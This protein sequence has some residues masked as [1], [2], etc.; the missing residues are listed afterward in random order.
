M[1]EEATVLR[2]ADLRFAIAK[3]IIT[4]GNCTEQ[5]NRQGDG[6]INL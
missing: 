1:K 3:R 4:P 6:P 5:S 2:R